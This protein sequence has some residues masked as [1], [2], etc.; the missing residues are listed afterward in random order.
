MMKPAFNAAAA[1]EA[2]ATAYE[3]GVRTFFPERSDKGEYR[4]RSQE[5]QTFMKNGDFLIAISRFAFKLTVKIRQ[6]DHRFRV[7]VYDGTGKCTDALVLPR[8]RE[9]SLSILT[10]Q[11]ESVNRL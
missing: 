8:M 1:K 9:R 3:N 7:S 2:Y 6:E 4:F 11:K 5:V 10:V